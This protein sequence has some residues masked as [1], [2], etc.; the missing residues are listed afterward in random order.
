MEIIKIKLILILLVLSYFNT[1]NAQNKE[2]KEVKTGDDVI[3]NYIIAN[4][5][6]ENLEKVKSIEM[7]GVL[8]AMGKELSMN[9]YTSSDYYYVDISDP[10]FGSTIA[11]DRK[12]KKGWM[13][14]MGKINDISDEDINKYE[15]M[16]EGSLW[17]HILHK[18]KY[19][20]NYILLGIENTDDYHR[21]YVINFMRDTSLLYTVYFDT[22]DYNRLKQF[23]NSSESY[24]EDFRF[25]GDSGIKMPFKI[26]EQFPIIA[27][28]Y[29]FNTEFNTSLLK[30]PEIKQ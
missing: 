18:E 8:T 26:T 20:I 24:F 28:K 12:N 22:I 7:T 4:G 1:V 23:K 13:K 10:M 25:I 5:G 19:N 21:A 27:Q 11:I 30:K 9:V 6:K 29:E 2:F 16:F 14:A 3:E 17:G 15:E